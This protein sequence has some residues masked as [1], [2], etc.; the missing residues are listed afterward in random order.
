MLESLTNVSYRMKWTKSL[1]W[2]VDNADGLAYD[3]RLRDAAEDKSQR[4]AYKRRA[5]NNLHVDLAVGLQQTRI[6]RSSEVTRAW[7]L[8]V[9]AVHACRQ[10]Q[11]CNK[12]A[13]LWLDQYE[14]CQTRNCSQ[15][16]V[17]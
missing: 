10:R 3:L 1:Y 16:T 2:P 6:R 9:S 11:Q 8:P 13:D 5:R 7:S 14:S 12:G 4:W 15:P 17:E